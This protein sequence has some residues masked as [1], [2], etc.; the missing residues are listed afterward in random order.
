MIHHPTKSA[1]PKSNKLFGN[2]GFIMSKFD[3]FYPK[4]PIILLST[5]LVVTSLI[6]TRNKSNDKIQI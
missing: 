5:S 2:G 1:P 4:L 6:V 3:K